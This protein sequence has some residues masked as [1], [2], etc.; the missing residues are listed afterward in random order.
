M[1]SITERYLYSPLS[2]CT[3]ALLF[4]LLAGSSLSINSQQQLSSFERER[5]RMMLKIIKDDLK[6]HYY[7]PTFRGMNL[8]EKFSA[9]EEKIKN[10]T[11]NS[12]VFTIIAQTLIELNDSHTFF[13]PPPRGFKVEYGWQMQIIGDQAHVI[14]VK[15]GSDA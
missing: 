4:C 9:A 15:P 6:A 1:D 14:A 11:S 10:A 5:G 8:D 13:L 3:V 7:D 2:H 12:Q